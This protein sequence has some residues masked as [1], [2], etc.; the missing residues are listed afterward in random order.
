MCFTKTIFQNNKCRSQRPN[1]NKLETRSPPHSPKQI[2]MIS[3]QWLYRIFF[4][5]QP[6]NSSKLSIVP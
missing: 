2:W 6:K 4:K 5:N 1:L 3:G